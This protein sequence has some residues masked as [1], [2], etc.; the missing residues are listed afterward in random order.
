MKKNACIFS[1]V[2]GRCREATEEGKKRLSVPLDEIRPADERPHPYPFLA[3]RA[4]PVPQAG[5]GFLFVFSAIFATIEMADTDASLWQAA[6]FRCAQMFHK[7]RRMVVRRE[8][9]Q[10]FIN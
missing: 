7:K 4:V 1:W 9:W 8:D 6:Q 10:G 3:T 5:E 2:P